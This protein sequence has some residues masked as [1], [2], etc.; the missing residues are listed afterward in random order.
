[1]DERPHFPHFLPNIR[2]AILLVWRCALFQD[3]ESNFHARER[4][5]QF[6]RDVAQESLLP[7]EKA[8]EAARRI[9]KVEVDMGKTD[10]QV[11]DAESY[12]LKSRRGLPVA[13]KKKTARC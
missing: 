3:S 10:C 13:P 6:M 2:Q 5:A 9:G 4:R 8:I 11:P 12:I 1:M 7:A